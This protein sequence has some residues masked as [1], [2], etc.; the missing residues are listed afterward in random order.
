[1]HTTT[2]G[3]VLRE[4]AYRE[5]DK[6]LT[7]L[8]R[9]LGK[10]TVSARASRKKGGG[11]SAA[12]Q[13]LVWSEMTLYEYRQRWGLKEAVTEREFRGVRED[14][15]KLALASY[16]A[17][18]TEL[19]SPEGVP[20]PELLSLLLN[21]LH[22]L[23]RLDRPLPLIKAAFEMRAMCLAGYEPLIDGC[24]VCGEP[25]GEPQFHLREGVLHCRDCGAKL[26]PGI[27]L[28]LCPDSLA[29]L[30][31]IVHGPARRLY[32]FRLESA[33]QKRLSDVCEAFLLTQ[34]ERG[35]RTLDFYKQITAKGP[36]A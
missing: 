12:A 4:A 6:I 20:V 17:E 14:L 28:P 35:F 5:S 24:A 34:L 3:I 33:A 23:E 32:S 11:I 1:M 8:T 26:A 31:H 29:A 2:H 9:E 36:F 15:D 7:V 16:F 19:L 10:V 13:M 18:V 25:A 22:A 27:S 21:A 30:T